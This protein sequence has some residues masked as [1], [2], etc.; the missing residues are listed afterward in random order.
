MKKGQLLV[1]NLSSLPQPEL[2]RRA[3]E[4]ATALRQQLFI[5]CALDEAEL[6]PMLPGR[7]ERVNRVRRK[8]TA[9]CERALQGVLDELRSAGVA[10]EG[11]VRA[12]SDVKGDALALVERSSPSFVLICRREHSRLEEATLAGDDFAIIRSCPAPVWVVNAQASPG[13]KIVGAIGQP[14]LNG[15]GE[16]LDDMI[17]DKAAVL[18]QRLGKEPHALHTFGQAGLP[19]PLTP[20]AEDPDDDMGPSRYDRRM[21]RLFD[22]AKGYGLSRE[23]I[24]VHEGKLVKAL[25]E[26]S[27]P[28]NADLIVLG[29]GTRGRLG[30]IFS[31]SAAERVLQ[32]VN[33]DVL[34]LNSDEPR[35]VEGRQGVH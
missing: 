10:A 25:E 35:A 3:Q 32:R 5:F 8:L 27:E 4:L 15:N 6:P 13:D 22:F 23:R 2:I 28:M 18:A 33:T 29:S 17:L 19:Q 26:M 34:I 30:R 14:G 1:V 21:R 31:G 7:R 16:A 9:R 20:A 24:H 11:E 12:T